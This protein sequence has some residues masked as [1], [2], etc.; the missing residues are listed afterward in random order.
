MCVHILE[1]ETKYSK[2]SVQLSNL[3][4]AFIDLYVDLT[5]GGFVV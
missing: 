4:L 3:E 1:K 2:C 5:G